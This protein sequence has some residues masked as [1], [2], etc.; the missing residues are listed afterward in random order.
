VLVLVHGGLQRPEGGA[1]MVC[2]LLGEAS[3]ERDAGER[4]VRLR[5]PRGMPGHGGG[6]FRRL[7][8]GALGCL[9]E[10]VVVV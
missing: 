3:R 1:R 7:V 6:E 5:T 8:R 4:G 2:G 10:A 9:E